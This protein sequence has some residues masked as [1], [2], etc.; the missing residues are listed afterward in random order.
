MPIRVLLVED[1]EAT[2]EEMQSLIDGQAD[3]KVIAAV[4]TGEAGVDEAVKSKPDVVVMDIVLPGI[5]GVAAT[6]CIV[7]AYPE[8]KV[9]ALSNYSGQTLVQ[10][11]LQAGGKG[12]VRKERAFEELIPA[13]RAVASGKQYLEQRTPRR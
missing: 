12:F 4:G 1:H 13:V 9:L 7:A 11:V 6:Q 2:R 10:A 5:T 3:L 8:A